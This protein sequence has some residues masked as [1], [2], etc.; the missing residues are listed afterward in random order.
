MNATLIRDFLWRR[1]LLIGIVS[2]AHFII[3]T[4]P[5]A[6]G[7]GFTLFFSF[8]IG[9]IV[10]LPTL[11]KE[12]VRQILLL[13]VERACLEKTYYGIQVALPTAWFMFLS[14]IAT[15]FTPQLPWFTIVQIPALAFAC[16]S[17]VFFLDRFRFLIRQFSFKRK[18]FYGTI[19]LIGILVAF[20]AS[21]IE[22]LRAEH[23][24]AISVGA[25]FSAIGHRGTNVMLVSLASE[26]NSETN[27]S[28]PRKRRQKEFAENL[29]GF[30]HFAA[31]SMFQFLKGTIIFIVDLTLTV[32]IVVTIM[33][34][35]QVYVFGS[36]ESIELPR[37]IY[38]VIGAH[39]FVF[40]AIPCIF[41]VQTLS[42]I[43]VFRGLPLSARHLSFRLFQIL[44]GVVL[45]QSVFFSLLMF[46]AGEGDNAVPKLL[47]LLGF[48]GIGC[49]FMPLFFRFGFDNI[50]LLVA[51]LF[52]VVVPMWVIAEPLF[53]RKY[54]QEISMVTLGIGLVCVL[55]SW[56]LTW[57]VL[58]RSSQAYRRNSR[59]YS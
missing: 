40:C 1:R 32:T 20:F 23:F 35:V 42:M 50:L 15:L 37:I 56:L 14:I 47:R 39:S 11:T 28:T 4:G 13:P 58:A 2:I 17:L 54:K 53:F 9:I 57:R 26:G 21:N 38:F 59:S 49:L 41:T 22:Q 25:V 34:T 12:M 44:F 10:F 7:Y 19:T 43:R 3:Y 33:E 8:F 16:F 55:I 6:K 45:I 18:I 29:S 27:A 46:L 36:K 52:V 30:A 31:T 51:F 5:V 48:V 24:F